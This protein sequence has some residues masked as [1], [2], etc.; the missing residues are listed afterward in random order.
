MQ[1]RGG[2]IGIEPRYGH[3]FF[4]QEHR[5]VSLLH[6]GGTI[7]GFGAF[8]VVVPEYRFAVIIFANRTGAILRKSLEKAWRCYFR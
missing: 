4:I 1:N 5:G 8:V 3:G 6:R 7:T 2:G